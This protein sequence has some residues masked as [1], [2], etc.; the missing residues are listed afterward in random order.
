MHLIDCFVE[1]IGYVSYMI[2]ALPKQ[3]P[4]YDRVKSD[5]TNLIAT[6]QSQC[7]SSQA[8]A[9]DCELAQFAVLAWIDEA[10]LNST[11]QEKMKWQKEQLQRV[12]FQTTDAGELFFDKLNTLQ[13]HQLEVRE[14]FFI[15]LALGFTGRY[16]NKGDEF[17]LNQLQ[18][19]NLKLLG[20]NTAA[21]QEAIGKKLFP[22]A[23]AD[24]TPR[25][26]GGRRRFF[27][28]GTI[29][30]GGVPVVLFVVL[31][32]VYRFVLHNVGENLVNSIR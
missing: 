1:L 10:L 16:C 12:Y 8:S 31:F 27:N 6:S 3:Q 20:G 19:S 30:G 11:W 4:S 15:C 22:Q 23:Y 25:S 28:I 32:L 18:A 2:Q 14:V 17:L 29:V 13:H 5:I 7:Q 21:A 26:A 24:G 9:A